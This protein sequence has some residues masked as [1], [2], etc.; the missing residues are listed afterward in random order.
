MAL[1]KSGLTDTSITDEDKF[2]LI[3]GFGLEANKHI[4]KRYEAS[5][6]TNPKQ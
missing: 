4:S 3:S 6:T 5:T 2:E 1:D